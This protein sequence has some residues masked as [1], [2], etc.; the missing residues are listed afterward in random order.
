MRDIDHRD[1]ALEAALDA[2]AEDEL[3]LGASPEVQA[4]LLETARAIG[5]AR[6]R[7]R[8]LGMGVAAVAV[9]TAAVYLWRGA[10]E[11]PSHVDMPSGS[12]F[13]P[14][15][16]DAPGPFLPLPYSTVP[17]SDAHIVRLT[18]PRA[19]LVS[20][21]LAALDWPDATPPG[22]VVADVVIGEDGLARAV[23]FVRA[24]SDEERNP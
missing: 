7:Q 8:V 3:R 15:S 19:A 10:I 13:S 22:S 11:R 6:R 24:L 9:L 20:L 23:R 21:G 5:T 17:T 14:R 16:A 4:R 18:V 2:L 1:P 12:D